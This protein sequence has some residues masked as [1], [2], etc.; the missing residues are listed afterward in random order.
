MEYGF[1]DWITNHG[2]RSDVADIDPVF[3]NGFL[4]RCINKIA[5]R[6]ILFAL[7]R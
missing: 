2:S 1:A 4:P 7:T 5:A 3:G 6:R